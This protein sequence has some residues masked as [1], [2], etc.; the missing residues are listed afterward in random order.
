MRRFV[1]P[2]IGWLSDDGQLKAPLLAE[3]VHHP[4]PRGRDRLVLGMEDE[5]FEEMAG[6]V[7]ARADVA[8]FEPAW[9]PSMKAGRSSSLSLYCS[10]ASRLTARPVR[11]L[12]QI[13]S[14]V[15]PVAAHLL[16]SRP[17]PRSCSRPASKRTRRRARFRLAKA[18]RS[19]PRR[20]G[21]R[22]DGARVRAARPCAT[23]A[24]AAR[25]VR[26]RGSSNRAEGPSPTGS[27]PRRAE[28]FRDPGAVRRC[29]ARQPAGRASS[30]ARPRRPH[31]R[32]SGR[33]SRGQQLDDRARLAVGAGGEH[34]GVVGE[35]HAR[36]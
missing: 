35:F 21:R 4:H 31:G 15:V 12:T 23:A 22:R 36:C 17:K 27:R 7:E 33:G 19:G 6:E 5:L 3:L 32:R 9:A 29:R 24:A 34:V 11:G 1:E 13:R 16:R 2:G 8:V 18:P 26:A 25:P 30:C 14:S 20:P 10:P 28:L